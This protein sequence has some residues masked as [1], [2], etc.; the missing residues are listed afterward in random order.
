MVNH[1]SRPPSLRRHKASSQAVVTLGGKDHYLGPWPAGRG[2]PPAAAQEGY[3]RLIAE[4]LANGRQLPQRPN[5][6]PLTV[7]DLIL[8]YFRHVEQHYRRVDCTQTSE[9]CEYKLALR[10]L[11]HLYK[12]TPA[13]EFGPLALKAVRQLMVDGYEHP[14]YGAQAPVSRGV[15]NQRIG[16]VKRAFRWAAENEIVPPAVYQGLVAVRGL[17]RG[18]TTARE[19]EPVRPV[20]AAVV[21]DTLPFLNR[22]VAA[23]VRVQLLTGARPG[24]VC[25]MRACDID[26]AGIVWLYRPAQHKTRHK[27]KE[28]IVAIGPQAQEVIK[29]FL[30]PDTQAPLFS[31]REAMEELRAQKRRNRKSKVQPSQQYRR[32]SKPRKAPGESYTPSSYAHAITKGIDAASR[33]RACEPCKRLK[34]TD[35]CE[36][37]KAAAVPHWHPHQ[38]RDNHATEVRRQ[39]GLEAA[40]VALGHA[41]ASVTEVYAERDLALA[42]R[43]AAAIG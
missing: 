3:D 43:V 29:P 20:S 22:Q 34:V 1:R 17:E 9:V 33:A 12:S 25:S 24:E 19:T 39:F 31:A 28:R 21:A 35:R 38:L 7:A 27:G 42:T 16:R 37:C 41:Q 11:A 6:S 40:Q 2:K 36:A 15:V 14:K 23:M 18:R 5:E 32:V 26:M 13:A 4:W 30:R 8:A 10:P